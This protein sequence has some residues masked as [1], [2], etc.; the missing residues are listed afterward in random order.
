[1]MADCLFCK[2]VAGDIPCDKVEENDSFLAFRDID[3][4][5]PTHILVI[6]KSHVRSLVEADDP[7]MLGGLMAF[8]RGVAAAQGLA[9][10]GY[11]LVINSN[12]EGGQMVFHIH[13]HILGGRPMKWPPG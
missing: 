7:Q 3:P 6:P 13:V 11:R 5:A 2:I 4:Q 1:M 12:D 9:P 10:K 8:S